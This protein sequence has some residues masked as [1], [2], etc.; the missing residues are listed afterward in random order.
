IFPGTMKLVRSGESLSVRTLSPKM[1][2]LVI[3]SL[4]ENTLTSRK[5]ASFDGYELLEMNGFN[6]ADVINEYYL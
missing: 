1:A 5:T 4:P 3:V 6:V 2:S